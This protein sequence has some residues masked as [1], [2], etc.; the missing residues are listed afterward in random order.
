MKINIE[1]IPNE[2]QRYPTVGDY[3]Y[4]KKGVLQVR[5]S[6]MGNDQ[7]AELVIVHELVELFLCK[8]KGVKF[9]DI[10]AF[11]K[12]FE[13]KRQS[14]N[15]DEPG[16]DDAAPYR[17]EH[18]FATGIEKLLCSKLGINWAKYDRT[19]VNL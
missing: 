3:W 18:L 9:E 8:A 5:V 2:K 6:D 1:V 12:A 16:D 19:V 11:D 10:D 14:G 17:E 4:D 7:Y 13:E 15:V